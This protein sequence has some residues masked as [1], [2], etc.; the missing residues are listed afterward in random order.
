[1]TFKATDCNFN[2]EVDI[3]VMSIYH[4]IQFQQIVKL[5]DVLSKQSIA[6]TS[7]KS[8][9]DLSPKHICDVAYLECNMLGGCKV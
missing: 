5:S 9:K 1:M 4:F 8:N 3:I 2:T 7:I 6:E